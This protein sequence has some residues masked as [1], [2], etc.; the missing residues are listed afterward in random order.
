M[1][2]LFGFLL[3]LLLSFTGATMSF[4]ESTTSKSF[5]HPTLIEHDEVLEKCI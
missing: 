2:R 5:I 3:A 1:N 4:A